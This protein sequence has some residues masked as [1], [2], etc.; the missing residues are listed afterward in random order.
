L[1]F[2]TEHPAAGPLNSGVRPMKSGIVL[3]ILFSAAPALA[4]GPTVPVVI[5]EIPE[6]DACGALGEVVGHPDETL[7]LRSGPGD[8]FQELG[9]LPNGSFIPLCSTSKDGE[10]SGV[11]LAMDG[12]LDCGVSSPISAPRP[13]TGPCPS[14]WIRTK[15]TRV[16][17]G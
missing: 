7:A 3:A 10:W 1:L 9:K 5:G 16:V 6:M 11:V 14:G 15:W 2:S 17:A 8:S 13:Y 4:S 12:V